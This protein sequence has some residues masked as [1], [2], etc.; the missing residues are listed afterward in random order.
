MTSLAPANVRRNSFSPFFAPFCTPNGFLM[1]N[2]KSN[3]STMSGNLLRDQL[4]VVPLPPPRQPKEP[5]SAYVDGLRPVPC[6]RDSNVVGFGE[7]NQVED[8]RLIG[9][10]MVK[11]RAS[12]RIVVNA[13]PGN[14]LVSG[15][16]THRSNYMPG[17]HP[18]GRDAGCCET[19]CVTRPSEGQVNAC[20]QESK[21]DCQ[22]QSVPHIMAA[23]VSRFLFIEGNRTKIVGL[24]ASIVANRSERL[25]YDGR[26]NAEARLPGAAFGAD[27]PR[28]PIHSVCR[29]GKLKQAKACPTYHLAVRLGASG[30]VSTGLWTGLMVRRKA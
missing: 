27:F 28:P 14:G 10:G 9:I 17:S 16:V 4:C 7:G 12:R 6:R 3:D 22:P 26:G 5:H 29:L 20:K 24:H 15:R 21:A 23:P 30:W 18:A 8:S 25:I 2:L 11:R 1:C 19:D 13:G